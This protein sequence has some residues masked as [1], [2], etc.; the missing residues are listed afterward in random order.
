M[1]RCGFT[2]AMQG[3]CWSVIRVRQMT[4]YLHVYDGHEYPVSFCP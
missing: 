3:F 1:P 2:H 4:I